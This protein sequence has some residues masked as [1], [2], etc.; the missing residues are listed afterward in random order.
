MTD[1]TDLTLYGVPV[2]DAPPPPMVLSVGSYTRH[3]DGFI[4]PGEDL[5]IEER[6]AEMRA[7]LGFDASIRSYQLA[8]SSLNMTCRDYYA[9]LQYAGTVQKSLYPSTFQSWINH[10]ARTSPKASERGY[11]ANTINRMAANVRGLLKEAGKQGMLHPL[12][13]KAFQ[14]TT[15]ASEKGL[16][17]N[18]R[19]HN[20]VEIKAGAMREMI[21]LEMG[22][23]FL[24][25]R[26]R[27]ILL[28]LASTGLRVDAFCHLKLSQIVRREG[29]W[30]F[31][32]M[33]KNDVKPRDVPMSDDAYEAIQQWIAARPGESPYLWTA[34]A[35]GRS[36]SRNCRMSNEPIS[37]VSVWRLVKR[38]G[39]AVGLVDADTG[40]AII[41][42]HDMRRFV[43]TR[44]AKKRGA[45]QAQLQLGHKHIA[46][47]LD[48]YVLEEPDQGV[49]NDL[50]D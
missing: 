23:H 20:R 22:D 31:R 16:K 32:V 28:T 3:N 11:A 48:N 33:G 19:P 40:K 13:A 27:A 29:D 10:L 1:T 2:E 24:A 38:Y 26:N 21:E 15:G 12:V 18:Q 44:V 36:A 35:G 14:D 6:A 17:A 50:L 37:S 7:H 5:S 42:P 4:R 47:T 39:A 34:F 25:L 9:Y 49:V 30:A 43:G 41:K 46:T 45:K 8:P